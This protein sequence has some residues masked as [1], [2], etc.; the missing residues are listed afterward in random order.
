LV[1]PFVREIKKVTSSQ[2][3]RMTG[4]FCGEIQSRDPRV[5]RAKLYPD[6]GL[7]AQPT[8]A[9]K[10]VRTTAGLDAGAT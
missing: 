6:F 5:K 2:D 1:I 8:G 3:D 4:F 10:D 9:G 7:A